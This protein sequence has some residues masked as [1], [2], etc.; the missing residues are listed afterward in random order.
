MATFRDGVLDIGALENDA[1]V[2]DSFLFFDEVLRVA[3]L[4]SGDVRGRRG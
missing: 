3:I 4:S 2:V 1:M